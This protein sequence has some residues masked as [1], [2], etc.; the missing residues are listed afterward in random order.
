MAEQTQNVAKVGTQGG[1]SCCG[2]ASHEEPPLVA[3]TE[4][5]QQEIKNLYA[6][7]A[8][9]QGLGVRIAVAG[10]GCSGFSYRFGFDQ[11]RTGDHVIAVDGFECYLDIKSAIYLKGVTVDFQ[12]GLSGKGFVF[13]NPNAKGHCG[14]GESFTV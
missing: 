3:F 14:C 9:N 4:K 5:A 7:D 13:Q 1:S 8:T 2:T 6:Q 11:K 12:S 10:G